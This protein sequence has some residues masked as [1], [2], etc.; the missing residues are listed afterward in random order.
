[1]ADTSGSRDRAFE[2]LDF[3][4]NVLK[5]HEKT[6]DNS[7]RALAKVTE[8]RGSSGVSELQK[9]WLKK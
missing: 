8:Q 4:I 9:L 7:I 3:I 2:A 5:E 6:L 1:M